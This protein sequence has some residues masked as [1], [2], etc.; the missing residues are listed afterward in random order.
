MTRDFDVAIEKKYLY[1]IIQISQEID[2]IYEI[3]QTQ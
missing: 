3:I 2:R 1:V